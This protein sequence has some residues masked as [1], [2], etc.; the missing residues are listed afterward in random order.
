V[1][2]K[3][4]PTKTAA[5]RALRNAI[6]L[7]DGTLWPCWSWKGKK[8]L[9]SGKHKT[10]GHGSLIITNLRGRVVYISDPV[11]GNQHDMGKLK[12]AAAEKI[13]KK[14][15]GVS[16]TRASSGRT[17]SRPRSGNQNHASFSIG[18]KNGIAR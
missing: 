3:D 14:A 8:K 6:A 17:T 9:W 11:T 1:T 7:V 2:D 10:T 13:L 15:S 18:R 4:R 16:A 12:G 5:A